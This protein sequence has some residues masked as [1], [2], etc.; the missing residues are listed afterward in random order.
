MMKIVENGFLNQM[1]INKS[2][3]TILGIVAAGLKQI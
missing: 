2:D 3:P 1:L